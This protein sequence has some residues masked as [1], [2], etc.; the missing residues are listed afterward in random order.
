MSV[1]NILTGKNVIV[2]RVADKDKPE[3]PSSFFEKKKK[4]NLQI[5]KYEGTL[6]ALRK[7]VKSG[8]SNKNLSIQGAKA[9]LYYFFKGIEEDSVEEWVSFGVVIAKRGGKVN[10]FS[11]VDVAMS[12]EFV[13]NSSEQADAKDD[14]W[15]VM[16]IVAQYRI[17]RASLPEYRNQIIQ[18]GNRLMT[19]LSSDAESLETGIAFC[20]QW[21]ADANFCKIMA[22]L[23][24]FFNRFKKNQFAVCRFG[25][26]VARFKDCAALLGLNHFTELCNDDLRTGLK[27]VFCEV[28]SKNITSLSEPN[29][30]VDNPLSYTPYMIEFQI[31]RLSPYSTTNNPAFHLFIHAM[32]SFLLNKRS[33]D[34]RF[35]QSSGTINIISNAGLLA[36]IMFNRMDW[37]LIYADDRT[38]NLK[39]PLTTDEDSD[40]GG[41][42]VEQDDDLPEGRNPIDWFRWME[43]RDFK[44]PGQVLSFMKDQAGRIGI[45]RPGSI[46]EKI[47]QMYGS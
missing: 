10:P 21:V 35:L 26:I 8:I 37:K 22:C 42:D 14:I 31:S 44:L 32:G 39:K 38:T 4:V 25:T 17:G 41:S 12:G 43:Q 9:Y 29:Q 46:G 36:F 2:P 1:Y 18:A 6:D 40:N 20:D 34:A 7:A 13:S 11:M 27:W 45:T 16:Y 33:V 19:S 15:M 3:Y 47:K 24:M 23:D 28:I 30:E 5:P